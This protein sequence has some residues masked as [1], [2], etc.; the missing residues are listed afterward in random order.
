MTAPEHHLGKDTK[1]QNL[2]ILDIQ[3]FLI[4]LFS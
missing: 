2:K 3:I 4:F 1:M